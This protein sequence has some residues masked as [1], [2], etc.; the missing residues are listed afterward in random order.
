MALSWPMGPATTFPMTA[1]GTQS[2]PIADRLTII[3][4]DTIQA[5]GN[6]TINLVIDSE[7]VAGAIVQVNSKTNGT[8]TLTYGTSITDTILTGV[9]GKTFSQ[10]F[11][12]DGTAF[13]PSGTAK[14]ID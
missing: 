9:A 7:I 13:K 12:Y 4:G 2:V 1:T 3:D 10:S 14:Q 8:E 5:T 11:I 6:R